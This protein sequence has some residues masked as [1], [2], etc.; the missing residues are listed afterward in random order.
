MS[1]GFHGGAPAAMRTQTDKGK[2]N[3][4]PPSK[5]ITHPTPEA[6]HSKQAAADSLKAVPL[7]KK[8][9]LEI[10]KE[11][12]RKKQ[13]MLEQKR[14]DFRRQLDKLEKQGISVKGETS[15]RV[16]QQQ[17]AVTISGTDTTSHIKASASSSAA[18][19]EVKVLEK[20]GS[21]DNVASPSLKTYPGTVQGPPNSFKQ[22]SSLPSPMGVSSVANRF[23]LDNR[24]TSFRVLP[25]IPVKLA[26]V[27]VFLQPH[28]LP[29]Q[30]ENQLMKKAR[31]MEPRA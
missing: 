6:L 31:K 8:L 27:I 14:N 1:T 3:F 23:K 12:L 26:N 30:L 15:G 21:E 24:P 4:Q 17:K 16:I 11:D 10:L 9:E 5:A 7:Q 13:E 20:S 29:L 28:V 19:M 22:T 2:Q 25:P 18:H